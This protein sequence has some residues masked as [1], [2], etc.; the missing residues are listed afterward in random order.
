MN[1]VKQNGAELNYMKA[2]VKRDE[3]KGWDK[4]I[5]LATDESGV[6]TGMRLDS[7]DALSLYHQFALKDLSDNDHG[8]LTVENRG[9]KHTFTEPMWRTVF[10]ALDEWFQ[11]YMN[12][13]PFVDS[14][15]VL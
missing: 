11:A 8:E 1:I 9:L 12:N 10:C 3:G 5:L 6:T 14:E 15:L 13:V 4:N 2:V 7:G